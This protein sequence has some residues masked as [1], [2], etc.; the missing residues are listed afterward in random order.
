M[1]KN[2]LEKIESPCIKLCEYDHKTRL[3]KGCFRTVDEIA[4][5]GMMTDEQKRKVLK[6]IE[7]RK[8]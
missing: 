2:R 3:C 1:E 4:Q 5:W 7:G 6:L 8:Q